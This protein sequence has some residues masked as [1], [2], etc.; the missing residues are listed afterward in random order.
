[1]QKKLISS[2][3]IDPTQGQEQTTHALTANI[4]T[5]QG[6][7]LHIAAIS[8]KKQGSYASIDTPRKTLL[9]F[10]TSLQNGSE[11]S[12][13]QIIHR[14]INLVTISTGGYTKRRGGAPCGLTAGIL[15]QDQLYTIKIG[16]GEILCLHQNGLRL[17]TQANR[18]MGQIWLG[19]AKD[20]TLQQVN[21]QKIQLG[22]DSTVIVCQ[23]NLVNGIVDKGE[24]FKQTV[25]EMAKGPNDLAKNIAH[26]AKLDGIS[27]GLTMA[28]QHCP[29]LAERKSVIEEAIDLAAAN[30]VDPVTAPSPSVE[31]TP[32][33]SIVPEPVP[34]APEETLVIEPTLEDEARESPVVEP[35]EEEPAADKVFETMVGE[36]ALVLQETAETETVDE[37]IPEDDGPDTPTV[38]TDPDLEE[39]VLKN[40]ES[41]LSSMVQLA[42]EDDA[43]P[44][45]DPIPSLDEL[46]LMPESLIIQSKPK[47]TPPK[48]NHVVAELVEEEPFFEE[49]DA[50]QIIHP[51]QAEKPNEP[52]GKPAVQA[53]QEP[54]QKK[55]ETQIERL[56]NER[57]QAPA[58]PP[59]PQ[60]VLEEAKSEVMGLE[61]APAVDLMPNALVEE[62]QITIEERPSEIENDITPEKSQESHLKARPI[63]TKTE[64]DIDIEPSVVLPSNVIEVDLMDPVHLS[65]QKVEY[66]Q[67]EEEDDLDTQRMEP[68]SASVTAPVFV[69]TPPTPPAASETHTANYLDEELIT[70][71]QNTVDVTELADR[72]RLVR[73]SMMGAAGLFMSVIAIGIFLTLQRIIFADGSILD[74]STQPA[75]VSAE[76]LP[77]A[78]R[79]SDEALVPAEN[80]GPTVGYW[81]Q[82]TS[83]IEYKIYQGNGLGARGLISFAVG[84]VQNQDGSVAERAKNIYAWPGSSFDFENHDR[85][86]TFGVNESSTLFLDSTQGTVRPELDRLFGIAESS[87]GCMSINYR[88]VDQPVVMAC[89]SGTCRWKGPLNRNFDIPAGQRLAILANSRSDDGVVFEP[90][91]RTEAT[92]FAKTLS[93]IP[94]ADEIATQCVQPYIEEGRQLTV[95]ETTAIAAG[96]S[97]GFSKQIGYAIQGNT[98]SRRI[99]DSGDSLNVRGLTRV[100]VGDAENTTNPVDFEFYAWPDAAIHFNP[101]LPSDQFE[102][103]DHTAIFLNSSGTTVRPY[104]ADIFG[105]AVTENGCMS[106]YYETADQPLVISCYSGTCQWNGALD[107][108]Y[109]IPAGQR[110]EILGN[111][112]SDADVKFSPVLETETS[113]VARTVGSIPAG[114]VL[115][116]ICVEPYLIE[117]EEAKQPPIIEV[118][119][120]PEA[121]EELEV[122]EEDGDV[123]VAEEDVTG[124]DELESEISGEED[125]SGIEPEATDVP[126]LVITPE[127]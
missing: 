34:V 125:E 47:Q 96:I 27:Q 103:G 68:V 67:I 124:E 48:E 56:L 51:T 81:T 20:L 46:P 14:A 11:R 74:E 49:P 100:L 39:L 94:Q 62:Q 6:F 127:S 119:A 117:F 121:E 113:V 17:L 77:E 12:I 107:R 83:K 71:Q 123:E 53:K 4:T 43:E 86:A 13:E 50:D 75:L 64:P 7:D 45:F 59:Q 108:K 35:V 10:V 79:G 31:P 58:P 5:R 89:Y 110:L 97:A 112:R 78:E 16:S 25:T 3:H 116:D 66:P 99:I 33:A 2:I 61:A 44:G 88:S 21:M 114:R 29:P 85:G 105:T 91:Y 73:L 93:I 19:E 109:D 23:P 65:N 40:T 126:A 82:G 38:G 90:I 26:W 69:E 95:E 22:A 102:V 76:T 52:I 15:F 24:I 72:S 37:L 122:E 84:G 106:M 42:S 101:N 115:A 63:S 57:R 28:V 36:P 1:M 18:P 55:P 80:S 104:V 9:S 30:K 87:A 32:N 118:E 54:V 41:S 98:N 120:T 60:P 111:P 70:P 92:V 8:Q